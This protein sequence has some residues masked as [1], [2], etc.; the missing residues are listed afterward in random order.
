MATHAP[1]YK[2]IATLANVISNAVLPWKLKRL[3]YLYN[4]LQK[5]I[6]FKIS[7]T[8][9]CCPFRE[10][11]LLINIWWGNPA[12]YNRPYSSGIVP[13]SNQVISRDRHDSNDLS[14]RKIPN[15]FYYIKV[16]GLVWPWD[17]GYVLLHQPCGS[18]YFNMTMLRVGRTQS[19]DTD[20]Q[21]PIYSVATTLNKKG[22][23]YRYQATVGP[24]H[25]HVE[26]RMDDFCHQI[27]FLRIQEGFLAMFWH[28]YV[29]VPVYRSGSRLHAWSLA[30]VSLRWFRG[31][32]FL[33]VECTCFHYM[34]RK[35]RHFHHEKF[36]KQVISPTYMYRE[37]NMHF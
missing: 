18:S 4:L 17:G 36:A 26:I 34:F 15:L 3:F 19:L 14:A 22:V 10:N 25:C 28:W 24:E 11:I 1:L 21:R 33:S 35:H 37:I 5:N 8:F 27:S 6:S 23:A 20:V 9:Q 32:K 30:C 29:T 13:S 7:E 31:I 2:N 16:Q 12:P